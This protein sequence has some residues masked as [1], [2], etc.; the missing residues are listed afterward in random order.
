MIFGLI[1]VLATGAFFVTNVEL[2]PWAG[3]L[4]ALNV[5]LFS[6][7][8]YYGL[9]RWLGKRDGIVVIGVLGTLA[10]VIETAAIITGFPYGHFGYSELLGW[11]LFGLT[12]WTVA[13]A[14]P[15]LVL[16]SYAVAAGLAS[17]R[18]PRIIAAAVILTSVDLVLDPGA[19]MLNFWSYAG[20]GFFYGVP[21]SNF[22]GW[23]LTGLIG[24][25]VL[26][27]MLAR[28]RP[29]LPAPAQLAGSLILSVSFWTAVALF[30]W[31]VVPAAIGIVLLVG[32]AVYFFRNYYAFD[33]MVVLADADG[34]SIGTANKFSVHDSDTPLHKAFSVFLLNSRG[35]LLLQRRAYSKK[36]WPGV[37]SN[38]CCGHQMLHEPVEAAVR[39]RLRDELGIT[40]AELH[41]I[42]P[43]FR[44]RAEKDGVVENEIC[45]V[46]VAFSDQSPR[47]NSSEVSEIRWVTWRDARQVIA[48]PDRGFSPWAVEE[49]NLLSNDED[50]S[51]LLADRIPAGAAAFRAAA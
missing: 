23:M 13:F 20:G 24:A 25:A 33:E 26:E 49:I 10:L 11:K 51:R 29:L 7:P 37:W 45:P 47:P 39:R 1:V 30:G 6:A 27:A 2:P 14:W 16:G 15:P 48:A 9:T 34:N 21:V 5:L 12:P 28:M 40:K 32:L 42:L 46:F 41:L 35:E 22:A 8:S 4:S 50:C 31:L 38:S 3:W 43:D 36:T 17:N 44:Y 19:V 18:V